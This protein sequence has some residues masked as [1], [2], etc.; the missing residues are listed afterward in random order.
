MW[1]LVPTKD[2]AS[3]KYVPTN[4]S[5]FYTMHVLLTPVRIKCV[6]IVDTTQLKRRAPVIICVPIW[7]VLSQ[8]G[9]SELKMATA[10]SPWRPEWKLVSSRAVREV[11]NYSNYFYPMTLLY[12]D[13]GVEPNETSGGLCFVVIESGGLFRLSPLATSCAGPRRGVV[14]LVIV[15]LEICDLCGNSCGLQSK[16]LSVFQVLNR[17]ALYLPCFMD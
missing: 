10:T 11:F 9:L 12:T 8:R 2:A 13:N 3:C 7:H 5:L 17:S 16:I 4:F 15:S 6:P 14:A 1:R